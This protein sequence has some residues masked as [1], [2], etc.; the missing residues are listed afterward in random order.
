MFE[1]PWDLYNEEVSDDLTYRPSIQTLSAPDPDAVREGARMLVAAER[2]VLYAGQG[3]HYGRAWSELSE[4]AE[5]L[6][7]PGHN[8]HRGQERVPGEP[9]AVPAI[10]GRSYSGELH[11]FLG[12]ADLIFGIGAS[13]TQTAFGVPWP[14]YL[15]KAAV[16]QA[17]VDSAD[18][19]KDVPIDLGLV[20]DARLTLAAIVEEVR[21]LVPSPRGRGP[22]VAA[23]IASLHTEW[24]D[25]WRGK[26][27]CPDAPIN[28]YRVI[29]DLARTV[30]VKNTIITHDAGSPRDQLTPFWQSVTPLSYIGWGKTTQLGMGLGLAMG[31]KLEHP[32]KLCINWWVT[33]PL[34]SRG[35]ISRP[36]FASGYRS[37]LSFPTISAWPL[38]CP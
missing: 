33:P 27:E 15:G 4:L 22:Q 21:K 13:F 10:R 36:R 34:A 35:W 30:D 5:L 17:T 19:H 37:C 23:E 31:A 9:P 25:A 7:A 28:P 26:L 32:D 14:R 8:E 3:V 29:R 20:G 1:I 18:L 12:R 38:N 16:I 6:E 24:M 11:A 2:P